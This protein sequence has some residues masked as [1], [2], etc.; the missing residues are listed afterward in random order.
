MRERE[1]M[2]MMDEREREIDALEANRASH[3]LS[4]QTDIMTNTGVLTE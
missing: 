2:V 1:I 3:A 4:K